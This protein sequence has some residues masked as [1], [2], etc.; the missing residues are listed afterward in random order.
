[1][2]KNNLAWEYVLSTG[3]LGK[4]ALWWGLIYSAVKATASR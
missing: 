4:F 3:T 1:M 2:M